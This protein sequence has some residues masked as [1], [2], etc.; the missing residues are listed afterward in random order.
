MNRVSKAPLVLLRKFFISSLLYNKVLNCVGLSSTEGWDPVTGK[1][2]FYA[3]NEFL[4]RIAGV[5]TPNMDVL[6]LKLLALP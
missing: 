5:G 6:L 4:T 3:R 2:L 1:S